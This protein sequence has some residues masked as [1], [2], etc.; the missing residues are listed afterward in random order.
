MGCHIRSSGHGGFCL[1]AGEGR[2][3]PDD[4]ELTCGKP[5][6]LG[7]GGVEIGK[8]EQLKLY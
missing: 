7:I 3:R 6:A 8:I 1:A 5:V 2:A 4:D